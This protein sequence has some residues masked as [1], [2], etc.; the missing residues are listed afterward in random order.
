MAAKMRPIFQVLQHVPSLCSE[1]TVISTFRTRP[2]SFLEQS[3]Q[4]HRD[5]PVIS[6]YLRNFSTSRILDAERSAAAQ[7][8]VKHDGSLDR[9]IGEAKELQKRTPWHRDGADQPPVKR[10]RSAGAMTKG[11]RYV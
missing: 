5:F 9:K 1:R 4:R 10:L 2:L 11:N 3:P 6:L 7:G 8:V